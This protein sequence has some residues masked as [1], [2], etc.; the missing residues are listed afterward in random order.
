MF[1]SSPYIICAL[2]NRIIPSDVQGDAAVTKI[3]NIAGTHNDA[4][5]LAG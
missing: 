3:V 4:V 1:L 2:L 5:E